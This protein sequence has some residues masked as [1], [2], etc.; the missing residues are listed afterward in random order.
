[1][2]FRSEFYRQ[3][4]LVLPLRVP[5]IISFL[6]GHP[7]VAYIIFLVFPSLIHFPVSFLQLRVSEAAPKQDVTNP[8]SLP[9]FH[10]VYDIPLLFDSL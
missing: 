4:D 7:V 2:L 5:N 1:M 8:V 10:R 9:S 3:C 6:Y